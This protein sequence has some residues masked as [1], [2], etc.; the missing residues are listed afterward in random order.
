MTSKWDFTNTKVVYNNEILL[1]KSNGEIKTG[2]N[3]ALENSVEKPWGLAQGL[4]LIS[5]MV[6]MPLYDGFQVVVE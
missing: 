5:D 1:L 4:G 3:S 6:S 2:A